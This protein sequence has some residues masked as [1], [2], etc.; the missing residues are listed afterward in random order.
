MGDY[1]DRA[2][3]LTHNH[4]ELALVTIGDKIL[5][6]YTI[7]KLAGRNILYINIQP[8]FARYE[9]AIIELI[10]L[11]SGITIAAGAYL[12]LDAY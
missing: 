2:I 1:T 12:N 7:G 11:A 3:L 6:V 10:S 5:A 4:K 9:D 8:Q